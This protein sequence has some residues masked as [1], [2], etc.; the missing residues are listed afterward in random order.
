MSHPFLT[1]LFMSNMTAS[2]W[3]RQGQKNALQVFEETSKHSIAYQD[4]LKENKVRVQDIKTVVDFKKL[5]ILD[6]NNYISKYPLKNLVYENELWSK[7]TVE[8][9]S[10][11][12]GGSFFWPRSAAEDELF[13]KY[14]EYSFVQFYGIN[15]KSTLVILT[16]ALGTWT[17][18]EKMAE[19]LRMAAK[20]SAYKMTVVTPG[21]NLEEVIEI[22]QNLSANYE[23]TVIVGYPPFIKSIIDEG[24][25]RQINW[26]KLNTR[27]GLGGE[28]YSEAWRE[29]MAERIGLPKNDL[30]GISGGYGAADVGM[31]V[32]REYP[33]SVL[34]RKLAY[35]DKNLAADLFGSHSILPSLLQYNPGTFYMEANQNGELLFTVKAGVPLVRYNIHDKGGIIDFDQMVSILKKH[36]IDILEKI[37]SYGYSKE[38]IWRLPFFYVFGRSDGTISVGGANIYPENIEAALYHP[39]AKVINT[40]KL[41]LEIDEN[42]NTRPSILVE[43]TNDTK[44]LNESDT[45]VLE[46]KLHDIFLDKMLQINQDF[47]DAHRVDSK[48]TDP[49]VKIYSFGQ[50]PFA[51]DKEKIKRRYV[52]PSK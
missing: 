22:V 43:L 3:N 23:Q 44:P 38:D 40:H 17:S 11:H 37:K 36:D 4:F 52:L 25:R 10:G 33:I 45:V 39:D 30:L 19:A 46:Q 12:S 15:K 21:S 9:S 8:K 48:S 32:G 31:S 42:M 13:P 50:G 20:K 27:L 6:K 28:G 49:K 35:R 18:G 14:I 5:P 24:I 7:Y 47:R 29:Y 26:K 41:T 34:I 1:K 2:F 16:L 51:E